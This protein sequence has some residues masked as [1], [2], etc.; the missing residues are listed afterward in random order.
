V[1]VKV[2]KLITQTQSKTAG[3]PVRTSSDI[4]HEINEIKGVNAVVVVGRDGFVIESVGHMPNSNL[5]VLGAAIASAINGISEMGGEL[6]VGDFTDLFVT[7]KSAMIMC[8]PVGDAICGIAG[9]DA[10]A[11][12]M[13]RHKTHKLIPELELYL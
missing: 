13:I 7:Y 6:K 3:S 11:L 10:S 4:L 9:E 12:G 8:F 2:S 1:D 5:D